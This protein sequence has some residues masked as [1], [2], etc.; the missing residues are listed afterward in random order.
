[1]N[2]TLK[3]LDLSSNIISDDDMQA[4]Y[5]YLS[6][7]NHEGLRQL[8][9]GN[10]SFGTKKKDDVQCPLTQQVADTFGFEL[11]LYREDWGRVHF[12][13]SPAQHVNLAIDLK[14]Q[15]SLEVVE[16]QSFSNNQEDSVCEEEIAMEP[17]EAK[18]LANRVRTFLKEAGRQSLRYV[19][20]LFSRLRAGNIFSCCVVT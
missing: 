2:S 20:I 7:T 15:T 19:A 18:L 14:R 8:Y 9:L 12:G 4:I 16:E 10:V 1:M 6:S 13:G 5:G 11:Q 3:K 17:I